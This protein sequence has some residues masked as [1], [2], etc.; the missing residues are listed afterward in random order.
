MLNEDPLSIPETKT[1]WGKP[2]K[3]TL[4]TDPILVRPCF[5]EHLCHSASFSGDASS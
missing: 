1:P 5:G 2:E 3:S 4:D